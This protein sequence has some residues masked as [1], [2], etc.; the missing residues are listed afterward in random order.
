MRKTS[1]QYIEYL[2]DKKNI[3]TN[4]EI[5]YKN[6]LNKMIE[7][8]T[9]YKIVDYTY[10]NETNINSYI[11]YMELNGASSATI[12]RNIAVIKGYFDYLFRTHKI[13]T[14]ITD[15]I[16]RPIYDV[17]PRQLIG[18]KEIGQLM[19][20]MQGRATKDIRDIAIIQ[21]MFLSKLSV[22]EIIL[23]KVE[24]LN[25]EFGFLQAQRRGKSV[26]YKLD[27]VELQALINY[28]ESSRINIIKDESNRILF[29]NMKGDSM[30]RQGVWKMVKTHANAAGLDD[31]NLSRL[32]KGNGK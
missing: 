14:C 1:A 19:D 23:L 32:S 15:D 10:I 21:L 4:T 31:I 26:T 24:D 18:D 28:M 2:K 27:E 7:Y 3:S 20:T 17:K 5:S 8:F 30:S 9:L 29:P 11:L 25:L 12:I 6:D 13:N 16:K 22:S